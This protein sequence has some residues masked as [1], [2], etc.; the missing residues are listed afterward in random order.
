MRLLG[1]AGSIRHGSYNRQLLDAAAKELPPEVELEVWEGLDSVPLFNEDVEALRT[2][3]AVE[4]LRGL[5]GDADGVLLATPE[6]NH[7]IPGVLKNALDWASRPPHES[8]LA[9]VPVAVVGASLSAYGAAWAQQ[10]TRT[11]LEAIGARVVDAELAVPRAHQAFDDDGRL[12]D[13]A[14]RG[15]LVTVL[16]E[17]LAAARAGADVSERSAA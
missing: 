6:Y 4:E 8:P 16:D 13:P 5:L 11:V 7:S 15:R 12:A 1:F 9:G 10:E 3:L 17:L 14:L 2:P